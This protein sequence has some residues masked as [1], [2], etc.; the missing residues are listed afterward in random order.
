M[1]KQF[2]ASL[3]EGDVL[4]DYFVATRRD[5]R[6]TQNGGKFLGMVFKD[7]TGDIGGVLWNNAAAVAELFELGDV[8]N[9][10]GTV[11]TYQERL[12]VRVDQVLPLKE[13]EFEIADLVESPEN[14]DELSQK[15]RDVV[16]SIEDRWLS[17][18]V[19]AFLDDAAFMERFARAVAG[20]KWHHAYPGGLLQHCY[21]MSQIAETMCVLY[22]NVDRD[23]LM[24]GVF[25]HDIGKLDELTHDLFVEYT[26]AG[27][28][29]GHLEI[30]CDMVNRK[31]AEIEEFPEALALQV[32][33]LILSHH[34]ERENGSP[35][36]PKT[37]E[38]TVLYHIDNLDAQANAITRIVQETRG[39]GEEWSEYIPLIDRPI[40]AGDRPAE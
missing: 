1:K 19:H 27:K 23:L 6:E 32:R 7:R 25:L 39:K 13:G 2:V 28:L 34:G 29:V 17:E 36:V 35:V 15:F 24:T 14:I 18:L 9:V 12:Q 31:I 33:H 4:N 40:W 11:K 30:G 16:A 38:A 20:K 37:L 10:R 3:Q 22:P 21:E 8:V 5:L 26:T